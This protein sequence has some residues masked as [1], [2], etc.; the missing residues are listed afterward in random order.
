MLLAWEWELPF[1]LGSLFSLAAFTTVVQM[2]NY[3]VVVILALPNL[4]SSRLEVA[5]LC[6]FPS[7]E[8]R[9]VSSAQFI[10]IKK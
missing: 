7:L 4:L 6:S 3:T 1:A 8:R 9:L 5:A 10:R 2:R